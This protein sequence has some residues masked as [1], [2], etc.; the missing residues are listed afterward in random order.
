MWLK[1]HE[2]VMP[3][4]HVVSW[5][6]GALLK[7]RRGSAP[8]GGCHLGT[9]SVS[10]KS[11]NLGIS[12]NPS[13]AKYL[14]SS[15]KWLTCWEPSRMQSWAGAGSRA[16][17][18]SPCPLGCC[19]PRSWPPLEIQCS[20]ASLPPC[21]Q[22]APGR[23]CSCSHNNSRFHVLKGTD[24]HLVLDGL[25]RMG[26]KS[27]ERN[28]EPNGSS[29]YWTHVQSRVPSLHECSLLHGPGICWP[30]TEGHLVTV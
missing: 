6:A 15:N 11:G 21:P 20:I 14:C 29:M 27:T 10:Q 30:H 7:R 24:M 18:L 13:F 2:S 19:S 23:N 3:S 17:S 12:V 1:D 16:T 25:S 8:A 22:E 5:K 28:T 9:T 26:H 4:G